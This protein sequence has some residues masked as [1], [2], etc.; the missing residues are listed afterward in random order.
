MNANPDVA[1]DA[2]FARMA[3]VAGIEYPA[4]VRTLCELALERQRQTISVEEGWAL[5]QRLSGVSTATG[6][7]GT[8]SLDLFAAGTPVRVEQAVGDH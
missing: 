2:G 8:P 6:T 4:L 1:P 7:D 5:A 3:S